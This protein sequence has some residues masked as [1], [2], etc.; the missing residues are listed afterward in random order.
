[1]NTDKFDLNR[2][3]D[4]QAGIYTSVINELRA[5]SKRSHWMW[6]IFPQIDGLAMSA[7]SRH[8][9]IKSMDDARVF[10][11]HPILGPRLIECSQT[12]VGIEGR[13]ASQIFGYPD[14]L[15]LKSS[16]TLFSLV[17]NAD[18]VFDSVLEKYFD[19][20]RDDRTVEIVGR[21][22]T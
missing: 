7:T 10:L 9:A 18:P 3:V 5:G 11:E 16:M 17:D 2:F 12:L 8:Y 14:D 15:K 21:I 22:E 6:F 13:S 4:A 20:E 1:M 19:G